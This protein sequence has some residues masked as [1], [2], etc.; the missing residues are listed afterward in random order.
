MNKNI[1]LTRSG[2]L[3]NC[4]HTHSLWIGYH[5]FVL[6]TSSY[7][8]G[9]KAMLSLL[10]SVDWIALRWHCTNK[11][12]NFFMKTFNCHCSNDKRNSN[13]RIFDYIWMTCSHDVHYN[14]FH[15]HNCDA[16]SMY[17][18]IYMKMADDR[19]SPAKI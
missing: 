12:K 19:S 17:G 13:H 6:T 15:L 14:C 8:N 9:K 10:L 2:N 16:V 18:V 7:L 3:F 4:T 1:F 11:T 5:H